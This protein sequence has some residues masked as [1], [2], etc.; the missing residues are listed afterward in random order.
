VVGFLANGGYHTLN[1]IL[2]LERE[3]IVKI[4]GMTPEATE[5]LMEFLA[6]LTAEESS[7]DQAQ[8]G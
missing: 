5:E 3:D 6:D 7:E 2:D 8:P 4:A 1:V